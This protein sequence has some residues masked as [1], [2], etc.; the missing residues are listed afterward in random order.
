MSCT[1]K[2]ARL[3]QSLFFNSLIRGSFEQVWPLPALVFKKGDSS[4]AE[5]TLCCTGISFGSFDRWRKFRHREQCCTFLSLH[6]TESSYYLGR[7]SLPAWRWAL[8]L[9]H[10]MALNLDS[11]V[12]SRFSP[13]AYNSWTQR[14]EFTLHYSQH[15]WGWTAKLQICFL[16]ASPPFILIS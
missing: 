11:S 14:R 1:H 8:L 16:A 6:T 15:Q 12:P 4:S 9:A 13:A 3:K 5:F 2:Y 10:R 7:T